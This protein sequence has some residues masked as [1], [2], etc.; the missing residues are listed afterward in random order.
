MAVE[1]I[2][3]MGARLRNWGRWGADDER[4]TTNLITPEAIVTASRLVKTGKVFSLGIDLEQDGPQPGGPRT[5][6]MHFMTATGDGQDYP[7]GFRYADDYIVMNLQAV[8]QWDGLGHAFYDDQIYNGY[9]ATEINSYGAQRNSIHQQ[10]KGIVGRGVLLD[11][12]AL[13]DV[14]WLPAGFAIQPAHLEEAMARQGGVEVGAGDVLIFHTG[15]R[16]YW[17][18]ERNAASF[19]SR[20]PGLGFACC[21]WLHDRDVAAVAA[22]NTAVEVAPYDVKGV[23][24]PLHAIL[25]RDMGMTLG[26]MFDLEELLA[27]CYADGVWE[28][29]FCAPVLRVKGGVGSPINPLAIK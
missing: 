2:K 5:N 14:D 10:G 11:I 29:F 24:L 21:E 12:A 4:G 26:E 8:T 13:E 20:Q 19:Q 3:A 25:I 22:D 28:F 23:M 18:A 15:W 7:G 27:D 1:D 17:L 6:P 16:R 9:P